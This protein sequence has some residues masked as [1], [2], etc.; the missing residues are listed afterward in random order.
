MV[1]VIT[2]LLLFPTLLEFKTKEVSP[3]RQTTVLSGSFLN[4]TI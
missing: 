1:P 4:D 2:T 3:S